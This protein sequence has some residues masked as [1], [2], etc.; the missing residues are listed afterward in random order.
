MDLCAASSASAWWASE[1][2]TDMGMR[3]NGTRSG[4]SNMPRRRRA[5]SRRRTAVSMSASAISFCSSAGSNAEYSFPQSRSVPALTAR[6]APTAPPR[7]RLAGPRRARRHAVHRVVAVEDIAH[8]AA[9]GDH[10]SRE[11]PILAQDIAEQSRAGAGLLAVHLVVGA[12]HRVRPALAN[13]R[14]EMRQVAVGQVR[15]LHLG[16]EAVARRFGAGAHREVLGGEIGRASRR[17]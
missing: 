5:V 13:R 10:V 12:H 16:V 14:L 4:G 7:A 8:R 15:I 2:T 3:A 1:S 6:A 11:A 9:I 17:G